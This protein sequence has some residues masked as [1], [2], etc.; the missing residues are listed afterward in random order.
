VEVSGYKIEPY[1]D[2]SGANLANANLSGA[3]LTGVTMPDG[4][5]HE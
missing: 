1:A 5:V 3:D 2:L 4:T